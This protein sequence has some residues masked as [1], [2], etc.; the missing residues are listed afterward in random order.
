[1]SALLSL[2]I[3]TA[4]LLLVVAIRE[5]VQLAHYRDDRALRALAPG[6]VCLALAASLG[7]PTLTL[8]IMLHLL[9][10]W[11]AGS[12]DVLWLVMAYCFAAFFALA[13]DRVPARARTRTADRKSVV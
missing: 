12:I 8:P 11:F 3:L 5:V 7:I 4:A 6:L 13:D 9:G 10:P 1:M 2:Q